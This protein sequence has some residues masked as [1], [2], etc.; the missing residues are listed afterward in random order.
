MA[1]EIPIVWFCSKIQLSRQATNFVTAEHFLVCSILFLIENNQKNY[2]LN[3]NKIIYLVTSER[4]QHHHFT[5]RDFTL[6][7]CS[8]LLTW[9][10]SCESSHVSHLML[11]QHLQAKHFKYFPDSISIN[12]HHHHYHLIITIINKFHTYTWVSEWAGSRTRINCLEGNYASVIPPTCC[13]LFCSTFCPAWRSMLSSRWAP[14]GTLRTWGRRHATPGQGQPWGC[15]GPRSL[16]HNRHIGRFDGCCLIGW[17][18]DLTHM[19]DGSDCNDGD[20]DDDID[21]YDDDYDEHDHDQVN[22]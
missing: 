7:V 13:S 21:C 10:N 2:W 17:E 16:S 12:H 18:G 1:D 22:L 19:E 5:G 14:V 4:V 6:T 20:D 3:K 11:H 15:T 8:S 9:V